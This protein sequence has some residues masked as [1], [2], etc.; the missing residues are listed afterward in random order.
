MSDEERDQG[1]QR[2]LDWRAERAAELGAT[3]G[4]LTLTGFWW[5]PERPGALPGLPGRWQGDA[6][7]ARLWATPADELVADGLV[8]DGVSECKVAELGRV[9]WVQHG[10][11]RLELLNRG[12]RY[13]VRARTLTSRARE[14]FCGVPTFDYD[15]DWVVPARYAALARP[16]LVEVATCRPDLRQRIP[17]VGELLGTV[18][19]WPLRLAV[20]SIRQ[21]LGVEFHDP[22]NGAE[23]PAWRQLKIPEPDRHGRV[24]LDFNR[25]ANM[26]FAFTDFATCPAP[27]PENIIGVPVRAGERAP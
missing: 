23:T 3:Y 17:V 8:V 11:T 2:W 24:F 22:T 14:A 7:G 13:A 21:G 10:D 9:P 20:T 26:W 25:T 18:R 15:P 19:D 4:W 16:R 5:L 27:V 6:S 12:G 1:A